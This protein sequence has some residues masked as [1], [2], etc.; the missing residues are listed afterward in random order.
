MIAKGFEVG[1]ATSVTA[2]VDL[3]HIRGESLVCVRPAIDSK[4][5]VR[6]PNE[7]ILSSTTLGKYNNGNVITAS[8]YEVVSISKAMVSNS[9]GKTRVI[10]TIRHD[11]NSFL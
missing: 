5:C 8:R 2:I 1:V 10:T 4:R 7:L 11:P 6:C 3:A 9:F